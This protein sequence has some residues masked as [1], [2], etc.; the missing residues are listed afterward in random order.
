MILQTFN[1]QLTLRSL[2]AGEL[3]TSRQGSIFSRK[4]LAAAAWIWFRL[5]VLEPAPI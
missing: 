5:W 2:P 1:A 4:L 3:F